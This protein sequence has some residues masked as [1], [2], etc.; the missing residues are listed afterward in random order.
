MMSWYVPQ[1]DLRFGGEATEKDKCDPTTGCCGTSDQLGEKVANDASYTSGN[2]RPW[3]AN[4]FKT[5]KE[6]A[7]YWST[8]YDE[9][10]QKSSLFRD[11]FYSMTLPPEVIEAV[12]ANLTILKSPT[13][14]R[15]YD[16]RLWSYEGCGDSWGCCHGSCTHVWN[17]AQA[18][19]ICSFA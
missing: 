16:G 19:L 8:H 13:V 18:I 5:I 4:K 14:M 1:T 17:Y 12:A 7:D 6:V 10:H 15:Q 9:L 3:Y 2:Y 11:T